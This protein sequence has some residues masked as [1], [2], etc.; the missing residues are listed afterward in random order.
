MIKLLNVKTHNIH[1]GIVINIMN[2]IT[3]TQKILQYVSTVK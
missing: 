3:A 2:L 1:V